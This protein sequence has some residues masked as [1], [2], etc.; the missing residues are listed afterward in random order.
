MVGATIHAPLVLCTS[1]RVLG[2]FNPDKSLQLCALIPPSSSVRREPSW[3]VGLKWKSSQPCS[4]DLLLKEALLDN[5]TSGNAAVSLSR[6][7]TRDGAWS[8]SILTAA[9]HHQLLSIV[10]CALCKAISFLPRF[11]THSILPSAFS[12]IVIVRDALS[13][14]RSTVAHVMFS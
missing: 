13:R 4:A 12:V 7:S 10:R 3:V 9:L 6:A 11:L 1:T 14:P 8:V 5:A 2:F